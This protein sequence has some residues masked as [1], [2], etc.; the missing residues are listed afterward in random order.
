MIYF[1]ALELTEFSTSCDSKL[2]YCIFHNMLI[3]KLNAYHFDNK[4]LKLIY[5]YLNDRPQKIKVD[6]SFS[7]ELDISYGFPQGII[8]GPLLFN[9]DFCDMFFAEITSNI[10][11]YAD[12]ATPYECDQHCDNLIKNLELTVDKTFSWFEYNNLKVNASKRHFFLSPYQHLITL[13]TRICHY[14]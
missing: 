14:K 11:N 13:S 8:L 1:L 7:S 2:K 9:T 3:A 12:D 4:A 6:F 5:D 10:V